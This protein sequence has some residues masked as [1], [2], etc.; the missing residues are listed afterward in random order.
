MAFEALRHEVDASLVV[1]VDSDERGVLREAPR[2]GRGK[3]MFLA[4]HGIELT[5]DGQDGITDFFSAQA[6]PSKACVEISG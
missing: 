5:T 6:S 3:G 1:G 2:D 4:L